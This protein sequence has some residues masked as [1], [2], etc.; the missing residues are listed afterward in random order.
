MD[1]Q[2]YLKIAIAGVICIVVLVVGYGIYINDTSRRHIEK[3]TAAQYTVLPVAQAEYRDIHAF[4]ED[5]N[6]TVR[7]LWTVDVTAQYEG[8]LDQVR[9][10]K[11][12]RVT[13]GDIL[14]VMRNTDL[15]GQTAAAEA[16]IEAARAQFINAEQTVNR[17]EYLVKHNAISLQEYDSAVAQRDAARAQME[18]RMAQ[19][20]VMLSEQS[21]MTIS[22]P[23]SAS[24]IHIYHES[25][26]YVRAG[27]P[28]FMLAD[29][30]E[31]N[32]VTV[33]SHE[34]LQHLLKTGNDYLLEIQPHQLTYKAYPVD[35]NPT[36]TPM[37][38]N[39]FRMTIVKMTPAADVDANYHE[40]TWRVENPGGILE[41]TYY[42]NVRIL[43]VAVVRRLV[44]PN[45]SIQRNAATGEKF[46]YTLDENSYLVRRP[47]KCGIEGMEVTEIIEG[48]SEGEPV[49][50]ATPTGSTEGMKV[51]VEKYEF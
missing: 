46:V 9:V 14:A 3:M 51:G 1:A 18:S 2:K 39:Q 30:R 22:A 23:R 26:K 28:I 16:D 8:V 42:D 10:S 37:K 5:L 27:E 50:V 43:S 47:V 29:L 40:V 24:I 41:P 11:S 38:I 20:D 34:A 35:A 33:L 25:G 17:Y 4:V 45:Q 13:E 7:A 15:L 49:V 36:P 32:A 21:K 12:Q 48:L 6:L 31:L 44:V 19:H